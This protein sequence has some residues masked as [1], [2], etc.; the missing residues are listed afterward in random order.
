MRYADVLLMA[1]ELGSANADNYMHMIRARA[2]LADISA[3]K[4]NIMAER[5][6]EFA[7]EGIRYWDLLRQ[8]V[9]VMADAVCASGGSALSGG[10]ETQI[11]YDRAQI[12]TTKGLCPIP[13]DQITKANGVLVQNPGW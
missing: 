3:S 8:G 1:A 7:F 9:E 12:I 4:E 2:G 6:R 10:V 5:A 11:S 13:Q